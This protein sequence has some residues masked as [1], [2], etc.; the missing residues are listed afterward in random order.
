MVKKQ[1]LKAVGEDHDTGEVGMAD[2]MRS[3][4]GTLLY[5]LHAG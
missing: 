5:K 4:L 1:V 3:L 2:K